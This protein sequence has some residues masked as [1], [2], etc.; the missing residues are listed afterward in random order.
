MFA[1]TQFIVATGPGEY[2]AIDLISDGA[3]IDGI[4]ESVKFPLIRI[5]SHVHEA[6]LEGGQGLIEDRVATG[7]LAD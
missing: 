5:A 6:H 1:G 2:V 4:A 7:L 3:E